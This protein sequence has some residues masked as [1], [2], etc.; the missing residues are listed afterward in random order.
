MLE[1]LSKVIQITTGEAMNKSRLEME[2][3]KG[4]R[5]KIDKMEQMEQEVQGTEKMNALGSEPGELKEKDVDIP[6]GVMKSPAERDFYV[7]PTEAAKPT[8]LDNDPMERMLKAESKIN[9]APIADAKNV[10]WQKIRSIKCWG[11][12]A[13]NGAGEMNNRTGGQVPNSKGMGEKVQQLES[14]QAGTM[15][16]KGK[17]VAKGNMPEMNTSLLKQKAKMLEEYFNIYIDSN[18]NLSR[19]PV[20]L[21][22]YTPDMDHVLEFVLCLGNDVGDG[23]Q[24]YMKGTSS[25]SINGQGNS[26]KTTVSLS[27]ARGKVYSTRQN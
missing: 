17:G 9:E 26:S 23:S 3:E 22:Q 18:G 5:H 8:Y 2:F 13:G 27:D 14:K 10:D 20:L 16:E 19:L 6:I 7:A 4:L 11:R 24:L 21:D 1:E 15:P 25:S 12:N